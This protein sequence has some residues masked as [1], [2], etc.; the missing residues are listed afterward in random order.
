[1]EKDYPKWSDQTEKL[2]AKELENRLEDCRLIKEKVALY[3]VKSYNKEHDDY[4]VEFR[5]FFK[6]KDE[7]NNF[8][9][10]AREYITYNEID[11]FHKKEEKR[12]KPEGKIMFK[13]IEAEPLTRNKIIYEPTD[14]F[15]EQ[16]V[17]KSV[18]KLCNRLKR[19]ST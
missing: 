2:R 5:L 19:S 6:Y 15:M 8:R 3:R 10:T 7:N 4:T 18:K 1:M 9:Y 13:S 16:S 11:S 17:V 14:W 12:D